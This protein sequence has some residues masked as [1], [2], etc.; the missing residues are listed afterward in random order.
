MKI[1]QPKIYPHIL[2][3]LAILL[4]N[5]IY[6]YPQLQ[7]KQLEG[8]DIV[9][10]QGQRAEVQHYADK[11]NK[12]YLWTNGQF[13]GMPRLLGAP[14]K[15]NLLT[16]LL[17]IAKLGINEPIGIF[18]AIMLICYT[19]LVVLRVNPWISL[20]LA[21][22]TG[23]TT[24]NLQL[25]EA[26]HFSKIRTLA[27]TPLIIGGIILLFDRKKYVIG[28][29]VFTVGFALSI[30]TRH[31]QMTYYIMLVLAI[32]GIIKLIRTIQTGEWRP[33]LTATMI[34]LVA[35][36]LSIGASA[37]KIWS[38][39][40]YNKSSMRG[41]PVLVQENISNTQA[42]SSSEVDGLDWE[43]A[44]QWSNGLGDLIS[45]YIPGYAG[46]GS[47]EK[48]SSSSASAKAFNVQRAPLYWGSLPFTEGPIYFGAVL[49]FL[50]VLGL[51]LIPG[52]YKYW[53][54]LGVLLTLLLS[55]GKH[56]AILNKFL[57][58]N[59]PLFNN[60][61]TPQSVLN[62]TV[63]L[64]PILGGLAL[65][66][67]LNL[68][69]KLK[70]GKRTKK[71]K[72]PK[73]FKN[74]LFW[75]T[76]IS[77]GFAVVAGLFGYF[78]FNFES[79][80]DARYM[81]SG[82]DVGA[83]I[84]DRKALLLRDSFRTA[85]FVLLSAAAIW[86]F[87]NKKLSKTVLITSLAVLAILDVWTVGK[88]YLSTEDFVSSRE[89]ERNFAKRPVDDQILSMEQERH[90]Y[91][92][93]DLSVNTFNTA[94]ISVHHNTIG[95][96]HPAKL[97]RY[98]D[99]IERHIQRNNR[100]VLNMLNT[101]YFIINGQNNTPQVQQNSGALGNAW[102]IQS[103]RS[104]SSPNDEIDALNSFDPSNE[105]ILLTAEFPTTEIK[106]YDPTGAQIR[107][108]AYEPDHLT[109]E[110]SASNDQF[111]VFSEIW[112][113][114]EKGWQAYIDKQPVNHARVNYLLRG[115]EIPAGNHTVEFIFRPKSYYLG[116]TIALI[117]SLL[118]L[119]LAALGLYLKREELFPSLAAKKVAS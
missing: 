3:V 80:S 29:I 116:E 25:Y 2:A 38:I 67:I 106:Q 36:I 66:S 45:S 65:Q 110:T 73:D 23:L 50:F 75:A 102:F 7:N 109:Y 79:A 49:T 77:A 1:L 54:G 60:F 4:V 108:T 13:G 42:K 96:Y 28:G 30:Y 22:A 112:Y 76:G 69:P 103:M 16:P 35:I 21:I 32:Y 89:F 84:S 52:D 114:P 12:T 107:L 9:A 97:Q 8:V 105:A 11:T 94:T 14:A 53:L 101:K 15:N 62:A 56:F 68:V 18:V 90:D 37:S 71:L 113:G 87:V 119:A 58:N 64:L 55:M 85:I 61:R 98:A 44:M 57:F 74:K 70:R 63:Y 26:G 86:Y 51:F 20:V 41:K 27:F 92:V 111:A 118:I 33:F 6:F 10:N 40:D 93:L 115:M 5:I 91:R 72:I 78:T 24:G 104:V 34:S 43:Y 82:M 117:S 95:G 47:G 31:P 99:I 83:F 17:S 81:Q 88:R 39:Y 19:L 100:Q 46:G 59:L 48:V